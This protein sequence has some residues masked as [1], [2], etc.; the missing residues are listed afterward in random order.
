MLKA[1]QELVIVLAS[2]HVIS[3]ISVFIKEHTQR[4]VRDSILTQC[5][6]LPER[7]SS[8]SSLRTCAML[9]SQ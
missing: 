3:V 4:K 7:H 8:L 6:R 1:T 2:K 9:E 5:Q